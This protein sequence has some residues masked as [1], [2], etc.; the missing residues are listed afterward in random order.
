MGLSNDLI[1][2]FVKATNDNKETKKESTVY[3]TV[4]NVDGVEYVQLDGSDFLTPVSSTTSISDGDRVTVMI[5]NHNATVTGNIS[6]PSA[7]N[8]D[9]NTTI[10]QISEF[11]IVIA[12]KVSTKE[13]D[14][15][16][17]RIDTLVA[18]N[19][20]IRDTLTANNARIDTLEANNVTV[21][22]KLTAAEA[23]IDN[24]TASK[25][26]VGVANITY[27]KIKDLT[28]DNIDFKTASGGILDVQKLL[29]Q[30]ITGQNA[31]YLNLTAQNTTIENAVIKDAMIDSVSANKINAGTINTSN[32]N[33]VSN[34]STLQISDGT[35]QFKD[36]GGNV[37][38]QLGE[39]ATGNFN[40]ILKGTD[41]S[42][43]L[44][45]STGIK[46]QAIADGLIKTGMINDKAITS[47]KINYSSFVNGLNEDGTAGLIKGSRVEIDGTGQSLTVAF[48]SLETRLDS[49]E[50]D[51]KSNTTSIT[52]A[53]GQIETL[54]S[55]TETLSGDVNIIKNNYSLLT[56]TV[57]GI[58]TTVANHTS[59]ISDLEKEVSINSS[60]ITQLNNQIS[61]KVEQTDINTAI[62]NIQIGGRNLVLD[63]K[64]NVLPNNYNSNKAT[65][66]STDD[67]VKVTY[68]ADGMIGFW[69]NISKNPIIH[70]GDTVTITLRARGNVLI[71]PTLYNGKDKSLRVA[72]FNTD[73]INETEFTTLTKTVTITSEPESTS[74]AYDRL[75]INTTM[76]G[77]STNN[78]FEVEKES[79]KLEFG[80]KATTWSPAPE[81]ID[82]DIKTVQSQSITNTSNIDL[83][84]NEISLKVSTE[85][86]T[87]TLNSYAKTSDVTLTTDA[88]KAEF[89]S[90]GGYNLIRNSTGYNGTAQWTH[91]GSGMGVGSHSKCTSAS[92]KYLWLDNGTTTSERYAYCKRFKLKPS[93]KYT[94]SGWF[95]TYTACQD[96]D[97]FMLESNSLAE[98]DTSTGYDTVHH[99]INTQ[100][101]N[102][103][104]TYFTKSFTTSSSA[105]SGIIRIDNNGY[106]SSGTYGNRVHWSCIILNEGEE[107]PWSPHPSEIYDGST[108]IDANGVTINN[109]ALTVKNKAGDTVLQGDSN[110]NLNLTGAITIRSNNYEYLLVSTATSN[111]PVLASNSKGNL[112]SGLTIG[113]DYMG[114][115]EDKAISGGYMNL[116]VDG[117]T[118]NLTLYDNV[119]NRCELTPTGILFNNTA[120]VARGGNNN[121]YYVRFYDGTQICYGIKDYSS[122]DLNLTT[123][124]ANGVYSNNSVNGFGLTFAIAFSESPRVTSDVR[125]SGY[126][127]SQ[128]ASVS[129]T[130]IVGRIW[131]S[132]Y[133]VTSGVVYQYIAIGKWK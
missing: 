123:S 120:I 105:M 5:K 3:G 24:L 8:S 85:T 41:G 30:F 38:L 79:I 107:Q 76:T 43:T 27:A 127:L 121:N 68:I 77:G 29:A 125:S 33:I 74:P 16:I 131:A 51:V 26:D 20:T 28:A 66:E 70:A 101:T 37:R 81:D 9:L 48:N 60:S 106:N 99:L 11:E 84:Q 96:F 34:D 104:W 14:A 44:I 18:D 23:N 98:T 73:L 46:E 32:V 94:F 80:N 4:K 6:S 118:S 97:V 102:N 100:Q 103:R 54:V 53:Q 42:T 57:D 1:S 117:S 108:I 91:N 2:Q 36:S 39:D 87:N 113:W 109:G 78:W 112:M 132:Y 64:F 25:L 50:N 21:N 35:M 92:G 89:K 63:T 47:N 86:F 71:R 75:I 67:G 49:A 83:L 65:V 82:S 124:M 130:G 111:T 56:Q 128:V 122:S 115:Y 7:K 40:F 61:L 58:S 110:G 116:T 45:D 59:S 10:D 93:T 95:H 69:N 90:T 19:V 133:A 52:A 119:N 126:T 17:A 114:W 31:Q 62:D 88:L 55:N 22:G 72:T 15:E 13:L 129:T 12:D